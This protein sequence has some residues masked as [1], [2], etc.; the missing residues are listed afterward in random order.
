MDLSTRSEEFLDSTREKD[1]LL[2]MPGNMTLTN[3]VPRISMTDL[4]T[5]NE[6]D[7]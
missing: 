5:V 2:S 3:S 6:L 4:T 7:S 1:R